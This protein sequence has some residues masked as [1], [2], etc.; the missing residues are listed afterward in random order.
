METGALSNIYAILPPTFGQ[1]H[2]LSFG[3]SDRNK[4]LVSS[5]HL[6]TTMHSAFLLELY[7]QNLNTGKKLLV[8]KIPLTDDSSHLIVPLNLSVPANHVI[9]G[10][11]TNMESVVG[12]NLISASLES[13]LLYSG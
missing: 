1:T 3:V 8:T 13:V 5:I 9:F 12:T 10:N 2:S 11:I 6:T 4:L 7:T